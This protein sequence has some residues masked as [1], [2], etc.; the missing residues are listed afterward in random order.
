VGYH[1]FGTIGAVWGIVLAALVNHPLGWWFMHRS[2]LLNWR[3]ELLPLPAALLGYA[4]G[5]A[6]THWVPN[7]ASLFH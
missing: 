6:A 2:G 4:L 5:L 7:P 1:H 3:K